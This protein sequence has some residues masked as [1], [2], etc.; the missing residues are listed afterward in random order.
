MHFIR[1]Q[2][3]SSLGPMYYVTVK[4][5]GKI[6]KT[7]VTVFFFSGTSVKVYNRGHP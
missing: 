6:I 2:Y 5:I 1:S 4:S 7:K 3:E